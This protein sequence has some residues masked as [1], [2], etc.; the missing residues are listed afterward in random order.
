MPVFLVVPLHPGSC[1]G[2]SRMTGGLATGVDFGSAGRPLPGPQVRA[3][4]FR[5]RPNAIKPLLTQPDPGLGER[6]Q[7]G[8]GILRGA[9]EP[10]PRMQGVLPVRRRLRR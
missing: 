7:A 2:W 8:A 5:F 4:D 6:Q 9:R 1:P 3:L 10:L